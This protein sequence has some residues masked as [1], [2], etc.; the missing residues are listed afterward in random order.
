MDWLRD[1]LTGMAVD[2]RTDWLGWLLTAGLTDWDGHWLPDW[3][4]GMA[5]DWDGHWLPD[6]LTGMAI[7]CRTDWLGW[8]LTGMAVDCQT[9]WLGWRLTAKLTD[10]DGDWF[11][12]GREGCPNTGGWPAAGL[13]D[14]CMDMLIHLMINR[15]IDSLT[16]WRFDNNL[17][18]SVITYVLWIDV[19]IHKHIAACLYLHWSK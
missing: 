1:W 18:L 11:P 6:W 14:Q 19:L 15:V 9:D 8:R 2:C 5:T 10:W 4:T 13:M 12:C 3:L 7:D 16:R 17:S